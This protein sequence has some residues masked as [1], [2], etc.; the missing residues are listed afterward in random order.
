MY[1]S[2]VSFDDEQQYARQVAPA[3]SGGLS[4]WLIRKGIARDQRAA[5][6]VMLVF[7][8]I[9]AVIAVLAPMLLS[10]GDGSKASEI[11]IQEAIRPLKIR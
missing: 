11:E 10:G 4:G 5:A 9:C 2:S 8:G 3:E 6:S 7:A 1:M